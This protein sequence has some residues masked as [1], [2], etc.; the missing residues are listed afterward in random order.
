[1]LRKFVLLGVLASIFV[2]GLTVGASYAALVG[3]WPLDEGAGDEAADMS[4]NGNT[5]TVVGA[6]W[7]AGKVEGALE[8][9]GVDDHLLIPD[10]DSLDVAAELTISAWVKFNDLPAGAW[11]NVMRKE[12]SYVL[13]ITGDDMIQMNT[14][15]GGNWATGQA[16]GGPTLETGVWYFLAG[17]K[18]PGA[19]L[20][21]YLD[22]EKIA[23]GDKEGDVDITASPLY[24]GAGAPA[25]L[26]V[27]GVIDEVKIWDIALTQEE[28]AVEMQG[29]PSAVD[30]S[31]KLSLTWG[32]IKVAD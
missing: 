28:I 6:S 7:V 32:K 27:S 3:Y 5:G 26:P 13:E 25:W 31:S 24:I 11:Q 10:S 20:E 4:G 8:F 17:T 9:D 30:P 1:M 14:W 18:L 15:A 19:G 21:A 2:V 22:G 29:G 16:W 12:G 23:E